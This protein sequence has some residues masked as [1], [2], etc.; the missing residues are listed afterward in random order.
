MAKNK[1]ERFDKARFQDTVR[2]GVRHLFRKD[3]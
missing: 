2:T 1:K 3:L